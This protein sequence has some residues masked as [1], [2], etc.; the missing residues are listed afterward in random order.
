L[1]DY[2]YLI[3][4]SVKVSNILRLHMLLIFILSIELFFVALLSF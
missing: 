4:V 1:I 3:L 2:Y